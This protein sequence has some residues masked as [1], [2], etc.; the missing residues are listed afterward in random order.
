MRRL[1]QAVF[2]SGVPVKLSSVRDQFTD[3]DIVHYKPLDVAAFP[4][5]G[6]RAFGY[7]PA[8]KRHLLDHDETYDILSSHGIWSY[9]G[10]AAY[11]A[12]RRR[13][14]PLIIH[15]HGMLDPW[16]INRSR[17]K[18][19]AIGLAFQNRALRHAHAIR[20]L[21]QS[22]ADSVRA[23]GFRNPLAVIPNGVNLSEYENLP[24]AARFEERHPEIK[25]RHKLLFLSR[26]HP[27]KGL[28]PLITAWAASEAG[29]KGWSLIIAGPNQIGH[30]E[31]MEALV[32]DLNLSNSIIFAGPLYHEE[33][34]EAL[35]AADGFILPSFSE[36]FPMALLEAAACRL[37]ILMTPFCNFP[38]LADAGGAVSVQP[39]SQ[40]LETGL[41]KLL[42]M[43]AE[44]RV[45]M[46]GKA[47]TLVESTYTW[48]II[49]E[50]MVRM[51]QW[52]CGGGDAPAKVRLD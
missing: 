3:E 37:P 34:R 2:A 48:D 41:R 26:V 15:P 44:E 45:E 11:I 52:A 21:C 16:A 22:E 50:D 4:D 9:S 36:G 24:D 12:S 5:I 27:K 6:P 49:A 1:W 32:S 46:A 38:E 43:S 31:Q 13:R 25:G 29:E 20:V 7:S 42:E 14:V 33:K 19:K 28:E 47:R 39:T 17:M 8:L 30:R 51:C 18:K 23:L 10:C 35:A 40:E